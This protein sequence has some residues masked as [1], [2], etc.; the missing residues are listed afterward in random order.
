MVCNMFYI[1]F[2]VSAVPLYKLLILFAN[3][4]LHQGNTH[5]AQQWRF[6][7]LYKIHNKLVCQTC[8]APLNK[9]T[10]YNFHT[11]HLYLPAPV[12][13]HCAFAWQVCC[14]LVHRSPG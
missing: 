10:S 12:G 5:L 2:I 1:S 3:R 13:E 6:S 7:L 14:E 9:L 8:D 11:V 4:A